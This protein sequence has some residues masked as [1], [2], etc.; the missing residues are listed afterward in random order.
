MP[1]QKSLSMILASSAFDAHLAQKA[2]A[3]DRQKH[4]LLQTLHSASRHG[5]Q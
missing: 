1:G 4:Q 5:P 3:M 2:D